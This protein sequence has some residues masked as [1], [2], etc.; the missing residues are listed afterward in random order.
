MKCDLNAFIKEYNNENIIIFGA[1]KYGQYLREYLNDQGIGI[2]GFCDNNKNNDQ[3]LSLSDTLELFSNLTFIIGV[4]NAQTKKDIIFQLEEANVDPKTI[5]VPLQLFKTPFFDKSILYSDCFGKYLIDMQWKKAEENNRIKK[6]F[7]LNEIWQI[8]IFGKENLVKRLMCDLEECK[9]QV[10]D[11]NGCFSNTFDAIV[12][13]D[14]KKYYYI[15]ERLMEKYDCPII[16]I[17]SVLI[18]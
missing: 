16:N 6:Y 17:W 12:V 7:E 11:C 4:V 9:I 14:V 13:M 8:G 18:A 2:K 3:I 10:V 15:E 5:I 1:G